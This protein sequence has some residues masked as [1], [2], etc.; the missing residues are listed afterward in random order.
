[1]A[2]VGVVDDDSVGKG[3]DHAQS[4][5]AFGV[6]VLV[7]DLGGRGRAAVV[8]DRDRDGLPVSTVRLLSTYGS[9]M[10]ACGLTVAPSRL[11]VLQPRP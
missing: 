9:V 5:A 8:R 2:L 4:P 10:E 6:V 11:R 3:A 1:M 7:L